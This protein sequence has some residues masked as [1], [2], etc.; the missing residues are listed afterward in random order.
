MEIR[1]K[2]ALVTG[3]GRGLGQTIALALAAEGANVVAHYHGSEAG[4]AE[5]AVRARLRGVR[6]AHIGGD[7]ADPGEACQLVRWAAQALA[8][9]DILVNS[10]SVFVPG[11]LRNT[12]I[13]DWDRH[14]DVNLRGPFLTMQSFASFL[15]DREGK[16]VN[17]SD[18]RASRPGREYFGYTVSKAATVCSCVT[19]PPPPSG[20]TRV[21]R[22]PA[23]AG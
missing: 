22:V 5:T 12:S 14:V 3:A 4:A 15:E 9:P 11:T 19:S 20:W 10:A 7:L 8:P 6:A 1:G 17:L 23:A 2:T 13:E 21:R 16:V 18:F